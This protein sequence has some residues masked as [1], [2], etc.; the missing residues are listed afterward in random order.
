MSNLFN[1][2]LV[3]YDGSSYAD[4]ALEI[5]CRFSKD[6]GSKVR[7]LYVIDASHAWVI[8]SGITLSL[9]EKLV[10]EAK[11]LLSKATEYAKEKYGIIVESKFRIGHPANDIIE[12][13][14]EWGADLIIIGAKGISGL[15]RL[16]LGSV[17][18]AIAHHANCNVLIVR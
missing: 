6:Y 16:L 17:A 2:I 4:K 3:P 15:K 13:A 10:S 11:K 1:K 9:K 5:A 8:V 18:E 14:E 12:E 7:I